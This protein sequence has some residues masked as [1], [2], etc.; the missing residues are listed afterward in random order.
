MMRKDGTSQ[1]ALLSDAAYEA[2]IK[3]IRADAGQARWA[4]SQLMLET[5]LELMA[6]LA[7]R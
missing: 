3:A 2:G 1:L 6:T 4:G 7:T 5:D